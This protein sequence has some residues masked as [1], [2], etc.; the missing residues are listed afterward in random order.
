VTVPVIDVTRATIKGD[1]IERAAV[2]CPATFRV[3][4]KA[5]GEADLDVTVTG[6]LRSDHK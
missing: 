6:V 3:S 4:T 5:S 2:N 1:G